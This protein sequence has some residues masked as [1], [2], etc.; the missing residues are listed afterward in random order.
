ME[1]LDEFGRLWLLGTARAN[2]WRVAGWYELDDLIADGHLCWA[3]IVAR[4]QEGQYTTKTGVVINKRRRV[5]KTKHLMALFKR[6][7]T[8]RIH[9]LAKLRTRAAAELLALDIE[10]TIP[11]DPE[12]DSV[13]DELCKDLPSLDHEGL[14]SEAPPL[15]R[16]LLRVITADYGVHPLSEPYARCGEHDERRETTNERLCRLINVDPAR[17]DVATAL[18][19]YLSRKPSLA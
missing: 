6:A 10:P 13:W 14:I 11:L 12:V 7:Y 18:R 17:F 8:N 1:E 9:D 4:Y 2:Y 15:L 19:E 5:R 3:C 16:R